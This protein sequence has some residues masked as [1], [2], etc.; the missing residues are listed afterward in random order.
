MD[1]NETLAHGA[2]LKVS[3]LFEAPDE[4]LSTGGFLPKAWGREVSEF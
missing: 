4:W 3:E 2:A 1:P